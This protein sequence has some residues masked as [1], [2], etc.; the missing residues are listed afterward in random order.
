[1]VDIIVIGRFTTSQALAAV[2][3]TSALINLIVN[4]FV[5]LSVGANVLIARCCG[6][7]QME[8]VHKGVHTAMLTAVVG[9]AVLIFV[10]VAASRPMLTLMGT[11]EDVANVALFL[12]SPE[13]DY[14]TG[15]TIR[16]DGGLAI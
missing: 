3:S 14:I 5:G 2:G 4:L 13:S 8:A 16:V 7:G 15:E 11:P 9:G 12:A 6:A 1:M 10:G